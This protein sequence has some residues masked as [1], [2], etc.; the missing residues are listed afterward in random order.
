MNRKL[1]KNNIPMVEKKQKS[2]YNRKYFRR[3]KNEE[4]EKKKRI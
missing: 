3:D 1:E 4:V 2:V